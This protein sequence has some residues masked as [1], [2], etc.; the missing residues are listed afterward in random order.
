M[1]VK[2]MRLHFFIIIIID[3]DF[4]SKICGLLFLLTFIIHRNRPSHTLN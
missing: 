3:A 2:S 4:T 1:K